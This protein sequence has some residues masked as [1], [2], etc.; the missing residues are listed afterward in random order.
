M[1]LR[2]VDT[3]IIVNNIK[4]MINALEYDSMRS[5]GKMKINA[6]TIVDLYNLRDIYE[7]NS[8]A[9]VE[10]ANKPKTKPAK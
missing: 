2:E 10:P 4:T 8:K 7:G 1:S 3:S 9:T 5:A 6:G